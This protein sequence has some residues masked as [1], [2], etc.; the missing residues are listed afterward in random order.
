MKGKRCPYCGKRVSYA[1]AYGSRRKAEYVCERCGKESRVVINKIVILVFLIF[2]LIAAGIMAAAIFTN[3]SYNP[4]FILLVAIPLLI[5]LFISPK[6][7]SF[8]PLKKYKKSMEARKAGIEYSDNL[9][10][11]DFEPEPSGIS[12]QGIENSGQFNINSD[13]FNKIKAERTAAR[14]K[15]NM[16][17][18][19]TDSERFKKIQEEAEESYVHIIKDVSEDHSNSDA[20]LKKIHSEG[21]PYR[22]RHYIEEEPEEDVKE[23]KKP[24]QPKNGTGKYTANRKF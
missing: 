13:V 12:S 11:S 16:D 22:G 17:S 8:E 9:M 14:E 15:I 23:Y 2:F 24:S 10:M 3:N 18:P 4:I 20:P 1:S 7:V 6:F 19:E 21:T 5:F